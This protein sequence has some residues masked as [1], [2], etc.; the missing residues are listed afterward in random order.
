MFIVADL[1][2][3]KYLISGDLEGICVEINIS[4]HKVLLCGN[5]RLPNAGM[6]VW[7]SIECTFQKLNT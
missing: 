4:N 6:K 2:S 1:V 3:L 5:Y 7:D